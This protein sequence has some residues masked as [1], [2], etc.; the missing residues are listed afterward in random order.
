MCGIAG[1]VESSGKP[2]STQSIE[3]MCRALRHRG[4]DDEGVVDVGSKSTSDRKASAVLGNRRLSV[5]DVDGGH[6]PISNEDG[7]V[8]TVL[9]GEIYNYRELRKSL[10]EAGHYFTTSSD[11]EVIVHAYEMYADKFVEY[12]DGMFAIAIWDTRRQQLLL[13]RDRFGK[14]PLLYAQRDSWCAFASELQALLVLPEIQREIDPAAVGSYLS[15]MAVPAP[16]TIYRS[17][18]KLP[19]AHVLIFKDGRAS[20][21]RY[22]QLSFVPKQDLSDVE[23]AERSVELLRDAVRKR[24]VSD[25][26]IGAFLSGGVDSSAVVALMAELSNQPVK[27]F[28]IGFDEEAYNELPYAR[29]VA[30]EFG[31]DH[32]EFVVQPKAIE[33]LPRLVQHFGEPFADSSAI[34]TSYVA[35]LTRE[36]V[37]VALTGDGGDEAFGG[38]GRHRANMLA[39]A[40]SATLSSES[41]R[42]SV[43]S[44]VRSSHDQSGTVARIKRFMYAAS[45]VRSE[46][47]RA[48]AGVL[49]DDL[50]AEVFPA[51]TETDEVVRKMFEKYRTLDAIDAFLAIDTEFY[52]PTD[53]LVKMDITSMM[54]SLEARSPFLDHQLVEF[55]AALPS[56]QKVRRLTTKF[57]LKRAMHG[58]VPSEA[59][60]RR[61]RGFAVPIKQWLCGELRDVLKDHLLSSHAVADGFIRG[62]AINRLVRE[63]LS[64]MRDWSHQLWT[65][66]MLEM[67]WRTSRA[68]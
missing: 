51:V 22:W 65:L 66:L 46:R 14:K 42:D 15:Y 67:W 57:I 10:E 59:L 31:C 11:T 37:T 68:S 40:V 5:I 6:Q 8:W 48:W 1:I 13:A 9:N 25:V 24:L 16:Q 52:L 4:P 44:L 34:P 20:L 38:Y 50:I 53:L 29:R 2:V 64:G 21:R 30:E 55:V 36:H 18:R 62:E 49:S 54:H 7:T 3:T 41:M 45:S 58:R 26:P 61:K 19:P 56:N 27:T 35:A 39:E 47:Y 32:H 43:K 33:V 12:L 17:I 28:S 60:L 63:H 23:A